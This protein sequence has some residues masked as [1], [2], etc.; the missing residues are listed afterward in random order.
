MS[1]Y[2]S[3]IAGSGISGAT[4]PTGATGVTGAQGATG[5]NSISAI[6][7]QS[8]SSTGYLALPVGTTAQRPGSANTGYIR[9]NS[10]LNAIEAYANNAWQIVSSYV[11][12][13]APTIGTATAASSS[14]TA[15]NAYLFSGGWTADAEL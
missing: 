11:T 10:S 8:N 12:P 14:A 1:I 6:S 3:I 15:N 7:D 9:V 5:P 4:G 2:Q 13:Y